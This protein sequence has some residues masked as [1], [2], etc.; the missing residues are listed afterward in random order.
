MMERAVFNRLLS[1]LKMEMAILLSTQGKNSSPAGRKGRIMQM[2]A[3]LQ[4][5]MQMQMQM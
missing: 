4:M 5:Q 3:R 1:G 2:I